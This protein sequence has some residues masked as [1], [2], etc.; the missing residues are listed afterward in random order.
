MRVVFWVPSRALR[1]S[2]QKEN[3]GSSLQSRKEENTVVSEPAK[4]DVVAE[5]LKHLTVKTG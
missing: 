3:E 4:G 2:P 5:A 1:K